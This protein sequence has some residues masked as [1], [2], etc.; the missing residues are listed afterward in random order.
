MRNLE[1]ALGRGISGVLG[2]RSGQV[3]EVPE[4]DL[5]DVLVD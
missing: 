5:G 2:W 1:G 4:A 3:W